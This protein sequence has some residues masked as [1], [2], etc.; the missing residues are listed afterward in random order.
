VLGKTN[1]WPLNIDL[2][3]DITYTA[4]RSSSGPATWAAA[5]CWVR[6][7]FLTFKHWPWPWHYIHSYEI[8]F[9]AGNLSRSSV[10]WDQ[11]FWPSNDLDI[12]A[13]AELVK[14]N[15]WPWPRHYIHSYEIIYGAGSLLSRLL[16]RL[17][18]TFFTLTLLMP[19]QSLGRTNIWWCHLRFG[20][21]QYLMMP[22]QSF[23]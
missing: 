1:I 21:D 7:T 18:R 16:G 5:E 19:P 2:D 22:P 20:W 4:T 14:T 9:G 23:G 17:R 11:H 10:G 3:L 13:A 15:M 8:I 12:T 6:P